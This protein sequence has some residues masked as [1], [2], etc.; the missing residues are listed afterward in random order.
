MKIGIDISQIVYP[1]GVGVYVR[2]L[3]N[4]LIKI[5]DKNKYLIFGASLRK[6]AI[7][8]KFYS[9][10]S[11]NRIN[12]SKK[13]S[14]L[15]SRLS[16][17]L[18]NHLRCPKL[19]FFTGPLDLFHTSDWTEPKTNCVKVTTIHDL[20]P[21]IYPQLHDSK[22][23]SVF[24]KKLDLVKKES[25]RIIAVSQSTKNDLVNILNIKKEKVQVIYEA[26]DED[27]QNATSDFK[28]VK[29]YGLKKY[30]LSD[31]IK[32][33]RKNLSILLEAFAQLK[34][35]DLKLV[36]I[37]EG[38][39][40][41]DELELLINNFQAKKNI[42]VLGKVTRRQLKGL[43]QK[44]NMAVFPSLYEGFGLPVLEAMSCGCPV[45]CSNTS[46]FPEVAGKAALLINP[47]KS[48]EIVQAV[49]KIINN[50]SIY[51]TL[52]K[53]GFEQIKKFSWKKA[54]LE[55]LKVYQEVVSS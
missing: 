25:A 18:F 11:S 44:A 19:E 30:L 52:K 10:S 17:F 1:G 42:I 35:K 48:M 39:W 37:G 41:Q 16:A 4:N 36:L 53:E 5:D 3:V 32:N 49:K 12:L 50:T 22:I 8:E 51:N 26:L 38:L 54:A 29:E 33:P 20:A 28:L 27:F 9:N 45:V 47:K 55:T 43:Y 34:I 23:V 2:N 31:A 40:G 21:L 13:F 46:S 6:R 15:P 24:K 7:L 14:P